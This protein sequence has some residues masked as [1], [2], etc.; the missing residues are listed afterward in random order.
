MTLCLFMNLFIFFALLLAVAEE[1]EALLDDLTVGA[2]LV[3]LVLMILLAAPWVLVF[4]QSIADH[5]LVLLLIR[6]YLQTF[7]V[8]LIDLEVIFL[9]IAWIGDVTA[10][11]CLIGYNLGLPLLSFLLR[12]LHMQDSRFI[13]A[14][15][16]SK[17][18][19]HVQV[20]LLHCGSVHLFRSA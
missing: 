3:L 1:W 2:V 6:C 5:H 14:A 20:E 4:E 16:A 18:T 13:D 7:S 8:I 9:D 12:W 10:C 15:G 17:I 19:A 11:T